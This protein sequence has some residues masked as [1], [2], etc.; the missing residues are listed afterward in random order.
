MNSIVVK[1]KNAHADARK[2]LFPFYFF[3]FIK[4][5]KGC[6]SC[7]PFILIVDILV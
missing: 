6:F 4:N 2:A 3:H 1:Y 7:I 5:Y